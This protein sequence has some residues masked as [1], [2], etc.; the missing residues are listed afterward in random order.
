MIARKTKPIAPG[1]AEDDHPIRFRV[2]EKRLDDLARAKILPILVVCDI[3]AELGKHERL[4]V[5]SIENAL[6]AKIEANGEGIPIEAWAKA[7]E[8]LCPELYGEPP[9]PPRP[10]E[11]LP[12]SRAMMA[13]LGRR[14]E[15]G[16]G[17]RNVRDTLGLPQDRIDKV[18]WTESMIRAS[19]AKAKA[20]KHRTAD[21]TLKPQ[22]ETIEPIRLELSVDE[23]ARD[24][25][26]LM[27]NRRPHFSTKFFV[28]AMRRKEREVDA[29][30]ALVL[31]DL[32]EA[33]RS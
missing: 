18:R 15:A 23:I 32:A 16:K 17:L 6:E 12:Q 3:A 2:V 1:H 8:M 26:S 33:S 30:V 28:A 11:R 21:G 20:D 14:F 27:N 7:C 22:S 13:A 9:P 10:S 31:A 29:G 4:T 24:Y 25:R 5:G 19:R